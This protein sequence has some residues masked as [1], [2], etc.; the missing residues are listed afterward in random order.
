MTTPEATT[1]EHRN[2]IVSGPILRTILALAVPVT[3]GM[4]MEVALSI[5]DFFWVGKL[6]VTAQDAIT[7]SM[8]VIWTVYAAVS[9][10]SI[11]VTA[12]VSRYIGARDTETAEHYIK[13][14]LSLALIIGS[15]FTVAGYFLTPIFLTFMQ[16][17]DSTLALAI[18]YLRIFFVASLLL[19]VVDTVYA[20][21]RASGDTKTPMRVGVTVVI[22]NL[23]LDPLLIF[24]LGP[25]PELGVTGAA[26][27]TAIAHLYGVVVIMHRLLAGRLGYKV[28]KILR[29]RPQISS[30]AK[31]ARI[32]LP[33]ASQQLVFIMVYWF[34][35]RFVHEFGEAAGAAM[36]IGNRME[37]ISYLTC[38]GISVAASTVVGQN[39]G[40][41][42][43]ERAA[44]GAWA[45]TGLG[46]LFTLFL[47]IF[48]LGTP[49]LLASIFTDNP[50]VREIAIDYLIILGLSQFAMAVEIIL[51][52]AFSGAGDTVP[53][54]VIQ[55]PGSLARIPLAWYFAFELGWGINGI[56]WTLTITSVLK[57]LA[58]AY[59][60]RLS[61]W[62]LKKI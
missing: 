46:I 47:S 10:I 31:I 45:S 9:I 40:A 30:M 13:Q 41:G 29:F 61:K 20:V 17:S 49:G 59:W 1:P 25:L 5:T 23:I 36:G 4:L 6:G 7:S 44:K 34:L 16:T 50:V 56:W 3:L 8:V 62:K 42:N 53:P 38:Y 57:C 24:G 51:E 32:G 54:M 14:A 33:I 52:G 2:A 27:A 26:L 48:F 28:E 43:P 19:F 21:F 22:I 39:L 60:F 15:L 58:T 55:I 18:P 11:G 12:L 35:I 37:S